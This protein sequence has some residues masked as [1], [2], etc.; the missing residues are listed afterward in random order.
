MN[1]TSV[2][3]QNSCIFIGLNGSQNGR[4]NEVLLHKIRSVYVVYKIKA[5]ERQVRETII[6]GK[7]DLFAVKKEL[8]LRFEL[9]QLLS[10][11]ECEIE[12]VSLKFNF[13][14]GKV[15]KINI[16]KTFSFLEIR[17][18]EQIDITSRNS[19]K[20]TNDKKGKKSQN[21][22]QS[23]KAPKPTKPKLATAPKKRF[24]ETKIT[25]GGL[26]IIEDTTPIDIIVAKIES[27]VQ[28]KVDAETKKLDI[29][30]KKL[31]YK[32]IDLLLSNLPQPELAEEYR[33]SNAMVKSIH[34]YINVELLQNESEGEG[35]ESV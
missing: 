6:I 26:T 34:R 13:I 14:N 18:F 11:E 4:E 21:K 32:T 3:Y 33:A 24:D 10:P 20:K 35:G 7:K 17:S 15:K 8:L 1:L 28:I 9:N 27:K 12:I 31:C 16:N 29:D 23:I 30:I 19:S 25:P 5:Y 22:M 2:K